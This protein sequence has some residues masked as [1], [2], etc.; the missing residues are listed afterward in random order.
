MAPQGI[1]PR[2]AVY[3]HAGRIDAVQPAHLPPPPGFATA[4]RLR[5][6]GSIYPGLVELHNHMAYNALPLWDVPQRY[7]NNSQWKT[8]PD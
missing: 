4:S 2:G 8:H 1:L 3:I 6:R 5:T 7:S